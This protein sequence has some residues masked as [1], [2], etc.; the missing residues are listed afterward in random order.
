MAVPGTWKRWEGSV[1]FFSAVD[2]DLLP[3]W[4]GQVL[5]S[6][7]QNL[8]KLR[9]TTPSTPNFSTSYHL[10]FY[11]ILL[12]PLSAIGHPSPATSSLDYCIY[13]MS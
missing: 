4:E 11:H 9:I 12:L 2:A 7:F 10:L 13:G 5:A 1:L 8:G 6:N 3:I